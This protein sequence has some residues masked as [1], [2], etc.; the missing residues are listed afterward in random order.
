M[1]PRG[2]CIIEWKESAVAPFPLGLAPGLCH[3]GEELNH[4]LHNKTSALQ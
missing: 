2:G 3:E 4:F 1:K